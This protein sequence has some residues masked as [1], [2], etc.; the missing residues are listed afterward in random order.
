M[1]ERY[2]CGIIE[3]VSFKNL[4]TIIIGRLDST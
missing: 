4:V 3:V 2:G 1:T